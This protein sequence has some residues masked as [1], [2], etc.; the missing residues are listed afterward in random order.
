MRTRPRP[1][2]GSRPVSEVRAGTWARPEMRP[3]GRRSVT[4]NCRAWWTDE[5]D[6]EAWQTHAPISIV[7]EYAV[8]AQWWR[9]LLARS[10]VQDHSRHR[11][12]WQQPRRKLC[13]PGI[14]I[15]KSIPVTRSPVVAEVGAF[16]P[17]QVCEQEQTRLSWT[18]SR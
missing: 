3:P 6:R 18:R 4:M 17:L 9:G 10:S 7:Q 13:A 15:T 16:L 2:P 12:P 1:W 8:P 5:M 11:M 14:L